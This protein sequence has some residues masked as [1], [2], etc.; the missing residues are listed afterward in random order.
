MAIPFANRNQYQGLFSQNI[1]LKSTLTIPSVAT[2]ASNVITVSVQG[3]ALGDLVDL[4]PQFDLSQLNVNAYVSAPN[5]VSIRSTN[6]SGGTVALGAQV[7][8]IIV[9]RPN[10]SLFN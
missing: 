4:L 1:T 6:I 2:A 10:P 7:F 9:S 3:A 5:V 8:F